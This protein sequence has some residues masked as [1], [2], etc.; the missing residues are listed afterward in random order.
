MSQQPNLQQQT[1]DPQI[2]RDAKFVKCDCGGTMFSEKLMLK[3]ISAIVSP[4]GQ[5]EIF[6]M[7]V[8]VCELCGKVPSELN[9]G[10]LIPDEFIARKSE[11]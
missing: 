1:L 10:N 5:Q 8:L 3:K 11:K 6:P 7:N 2:V 9:P 4:T